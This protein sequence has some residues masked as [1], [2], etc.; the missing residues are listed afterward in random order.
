[1]SV[2]LKVYDNGDHTLLVWLPADGKRI[3]SCRGFTIRRVLKGKDGNKDQERFLYSFVGFADGEKVDPNAP[4]KFPLQRFMWSDYYVSPGDVVQYSL[5]PVVGP[6][7]D[8]LGLSTADASELTPP[9][10]VTGQMTPHV[11][12]Y[13][14]K[15]I[16]A[17]QWV[18]R[19]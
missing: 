14:N 15:G 2:N 17:A 13:F 10:T 1:M 19:G 9:M 8:H 18:T 4:W 6:D 5:I 3:P 12:A 16:V 7:K 11:A